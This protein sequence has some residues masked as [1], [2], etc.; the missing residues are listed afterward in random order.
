[1]RIAA[2]AFA[3]PLAIALHASPVRAESPAAGHPILG[4]WSFTLPNGCEET[5]RFRSDGT[6][7]V[8]S[9]DEV[10]ESTYRISAKPDA[11]GYYEWYDTVTKDNGK[12]DCQGEVTEVGQKVTN[13]VLFHQ[14]RD[15]FIVC[16][17]PALDACFG[18]L[19]R[20]HAQEA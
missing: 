13:Y 4:T 7:I 17:S 11:D 10:A 15:W 16:R 2:V 8:T 18:P 5:Y 1:M 20:V 14:S 9:G 6:T 19:K 12:E 3:A